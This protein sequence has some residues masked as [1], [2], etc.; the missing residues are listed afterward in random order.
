MGLSIDFFYMELLKHSEL[1]G[2]Y[3]KDMGQKVYCKFGIDCAVFISMDYK[4][5]CLVQKWYGN[6]TVCEA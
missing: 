3:F 5:S 6:W 2:N 4:H 1:K